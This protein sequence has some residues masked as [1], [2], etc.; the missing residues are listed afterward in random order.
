MFRLFLYLSVGALA[1]G[2]FH[3]PQVAH[4]QERVAK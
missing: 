4:Q 2:S 1:P 3:L